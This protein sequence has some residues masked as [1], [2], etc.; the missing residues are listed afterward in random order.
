MDPNG[1][2]KNLF[3]KL[4]NSRV[5]IYKGS[6][7]ETFCMAVAESQMLGVPAVVGNLGCLKE[8]VIDRK[9]GFVCKNDEEFCENTIKLLN[10]NQLW[11]NMN[12]ELRKKKNYF[13]WKEVAEKWQKIIT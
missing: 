5:F 1:G 8:R 12:K 4:E 6:M 9:T 10:D 3:N 11:R 13:T 7:D 2:K